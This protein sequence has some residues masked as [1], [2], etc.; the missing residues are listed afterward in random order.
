MER[1]FTAALFMLFIVPNLGAQTLRIASYNLRFAN[2]G[3]SLN[4]WRYRKSTVS[5]LIRFHDFDIF[6]TQE[7][8]HQQLTELKAELKL[9]DYTGIGRNDGKAAGEFCAIFYKKSKFSFR[10]GGTFWLSEKD[11]DKPIKGWDAVLPR[12]CTWGLFKDN[13]S[14]LSFYFFNTH[15]DHKGVQARLESS[16]L[17]LSK[18]KQ[19][20]GNSP[21]V[22][23]G[24]FNVDQHD[25]SY[26]ILND[27][28]L[29]EDAYRLADIKL[30]NNGTFNGFRVGT[31][32]SSRIDHIF[33]S[34]N[35][36]V[37]RY[38]ILT[39]S[40]QGRLP[41]DHYPVLIVVEP[42]TGKK[43]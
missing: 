11:T 32:S 15:F 41:S 40:Y 38:G 42:K 24:D 8:L 39:D 18:I 6:G 3:D 22:L 23:A 26:A 13:E 33:L 10:K 5:D 16:K 14:G 25:N 17:I 21:V 1:V 28:P 43:D 12:I 4:A 29:I 31:T 9:Y 7:G 30:A 2:E 34:N 35:F 27:S 37:N 36:K 20:A 19:I